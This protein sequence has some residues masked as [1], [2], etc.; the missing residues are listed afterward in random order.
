MR[1]P[2]TYTD[3]LDA[4]LPALRP[5]ILEEEAV[6]HNIANTR[7]ICSWRG[8]TPQQI[9]DLGTTIRTHDEALAFYNNPVNGWEVEP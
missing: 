8:A 3:V 2:R 5:V 4:D 7:C 6:R 9:T 1:E